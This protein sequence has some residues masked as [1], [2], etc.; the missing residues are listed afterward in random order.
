M[1]SVFGAEG[2]SGGLGS[3]WGRKAKYPSDGL[4]ASSVVAVGRLLVDVE[5]VEPNN[6]D[7]RGH[8]EGKPGL[9][10]PGLVV[11]VV[12]EV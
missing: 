12:N 8:D 6:A 4:K 7:W 11:V 5:E 3:D 2:G 1:V 10:V 9:V